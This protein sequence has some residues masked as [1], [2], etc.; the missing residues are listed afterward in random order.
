MLESYI[1]KTD[2]NLMRNVGDVVNA[3]NAF[4]SKKRNSL[5][6]LLESRYVWMNDFIEKNDYVLEF[7]SGA[8]FA[9]FFI[10]EPMVTSDVTNHEWI[11]KYVDANNIEIDNNSVDVI[12]L[13]HMLHHVA[14]PYVFLKK[15]STLLT[16]NGKLII[17]DVYTSVFMKIILRV[18]RHEGWCDAVDVFSKDTICNQPDDPWSANCAIPKLLFNNKDKFHEHFPELEIIKYSINECLLFPLSGGVIAKSSFIP[19][20]PKKIIPA[21]KAFDRLVSKFMPNLLSVGMS[22]VIQKKS[23]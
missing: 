13:S 4:I 20:C 19:D 7:G 17:Q 18:M 12:I 8:G 15:L 5:Y 11:D 22:V 1:P 9:K 23:L 16:E 10:E 6:A 21:I 2:E 14:K 3:R